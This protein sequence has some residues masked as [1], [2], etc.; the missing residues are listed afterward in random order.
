MAST[1]LALLLLSVPQV[2]GNWPSVQELPAGTPIKLVM[3]AGDIECTLVAANA[4]EIVI[5][6]KR[7]D[8]SIDRVNI[9]RL[10]RRL[11]ESNR[12][13]NT[14]RG[15]AWGFVGGL[16]RSAV[17]CHEC[18]APGRVLVTFQS[19]LIGALVGATAPAVKWETV[20][21]REK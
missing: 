21:R 7:G 16:V 17:A 4:E 8:L 13:N 11:P 18:A 19:V 5:H 10:D 20:Y 3:N 9:K 14:D 12:G 6:L 15:A 1:L 2:P